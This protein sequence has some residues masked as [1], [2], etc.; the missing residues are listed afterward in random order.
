M[1]DASAVAFRAMTMGA[2]FK[3]QLRPELIYVYDRT[4]LI[5]GREGYKAMPASHRRDYDRAI[6][7]WKALSETERLTVIEEL[8]AWTRSHLPSEDSPSPMTH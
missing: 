5:V 2:M 3:A 8:R 4:A 1:E 7:A 6:R